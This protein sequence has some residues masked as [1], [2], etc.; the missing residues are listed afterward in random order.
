[1]IAAT[2]EV[3]TS[4]FTLDNLQPL[5]TA[6]VPVTAGSISSISSLGCSKGK[7]EAVWI[8]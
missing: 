8:T 5:K 4:R 3:T 1:M 7:G 2:L 6:L